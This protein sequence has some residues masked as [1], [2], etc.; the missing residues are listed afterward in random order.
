MSHEFSFDPQLPYVLIK[1][2]GAITPASFQAQFRELIEHPQWRSGTNILSDYSDAEVQE[3]TSEDVRNMA[4]GY[5]ALAPKLGPGRS[6]IFA[7]ES[8]KYGL[9]RMWV[10]WTEMKVER[11]VQVF[12]S[13][14]KAIEW[15]TADPEGGEERA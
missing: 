15:L 10:S 13:M 4:V 12:T 2:S 8:L 1:A 3:V 11:E 9:A 6:A 5:A 7:S 14:D